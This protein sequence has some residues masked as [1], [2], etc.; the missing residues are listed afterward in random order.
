M[1]H[2]LKCGN[3]ADFSF[4]VLEVQTLHIRDLAGEKRV[5]AL[6]NFQN[7]SVCSDCAKAHLSAIK[8]PGA[9]VVKRSII[10][11]SILILGLVLVM[12]FWQSNGSLRLT[13][14]AAIICGILGLITSSRSALQRQ[15]AYAELDTEQAMA[16]SAWE[17]LLESAPSKSTDADL[18]YIPVDQKTLAA[19]NGDLMILYDLL[20]EIAVK[21]HGLLHSKH[22]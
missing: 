18:T 9:T 11:G 3:T 12:L 5:Q 16:R 14:L 22:N 2:C 20:P 17:V 15:K 10:F 1:A 8:S 4:R 6:G 7:Y 21:A 19:K 13:G